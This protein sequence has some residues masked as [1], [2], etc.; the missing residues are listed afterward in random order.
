MAREELWTRS[1]GTCVLSICRRRERAAPPP[2][3]KM[4]K[5]LKPC[6]GT[7]PAAGSCAGRRAREEAAPRLLWGAGAPPVLRRS[8]DVLPP[9]WP[10]AA[11]V[12]VPWKPLS[13]LRA[14]VCGAVPTAG[15][16]WAVLE[17]R[18]GGDAPTYATFEAIKLPRGRS[19][20][21]AVGFFSPPGLL[22]GPR[23]ASL[24]TAPV[25]VSPCPLCWVNN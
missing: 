1:G 9:R 12:P 7:K 2:L 16:S 21:F 4:P 13:C 22:P 20:A 19:A 11:A 15:R 23:C 3:P 8:V 25:T 18:A 5:G 14:A 10:F 6:V 17:H 24:P